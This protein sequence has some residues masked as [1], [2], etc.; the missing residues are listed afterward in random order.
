MIAD[1]SKHNFK[2]EQGFV[3][4]KKT[5]I[6]IAV[7]VWTPI[8]GEK[9]IE[10]E[11]P[12]HAVLKSGVWHVEGSLPQNVLGGVAEAEISKDDARILRISH[13]K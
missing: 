2:P 7:A 13:G 11:K 10:S 4:D 3:P 5:A 1:E 6:A 12:F 8:Y 9:Q